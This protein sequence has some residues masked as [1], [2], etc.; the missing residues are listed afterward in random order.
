MTTSHICGMTTSICPKE[1]TTGGGA[2][3]SFGEQPT[4]TPCP[5]EGTEPKLSLPRES[6]RLYSKHREQ[7]Q[8]FIEDGLVIVLAKRH[9]L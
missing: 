2:L 9:V 1:D 4:S 5:P 8:K 6:L 7:D 3:T